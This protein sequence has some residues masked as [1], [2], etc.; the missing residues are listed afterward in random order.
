MCP[1]QLSILFILVSLFAIL[2]YEG[3]IFDV[4]GVAA[5]TVSAGTDSIK[6]VKHGTEIS[7]GG[8]NVVKILNKEH[9]VPYDWGAGKAVYITFLSAIFMGT[10]ILEGVDTSIMAKTTP[11]GLNDTFMNSGLLA[12]L[13]GTV[14]RVVGDS[15][16]TLSALVDQDVFTD[17]VNVSD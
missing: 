6:S 11:A 10:I 16:I 17:F 2:N 15:M 5:E 8:T 13:V 7:I 3:L 12:T 1:L 9:E 14:G 4:M